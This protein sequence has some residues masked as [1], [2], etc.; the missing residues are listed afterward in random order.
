MASE[1]EKYRTPEVAKLAMSPMGISLAV[2]GVVAGLL[3]GSLVVGILLGFVLWASRIVVG[4]ARQG[5]PTGRSRS[6]EIDPFA[7]GEPWRH[8]VRDAMQARTRFAESVAHAGSGPLRDRLD[9]IG[10]R[11][12]D[13]IDQTW[14][15]A[16][17]GHELRRAR[18][19]IDTESVRHRLSEAESQL[20][21]MAVDDTAGRTVRA[22]QSQLDSAERLDKV[23]DNAERQLRLLQAQLDEATARASELAA[24]A[25]LG[26]TDLADVG[27]D[28]DHVVDE[29]EALR[30]ALDELGPG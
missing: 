2:V 12:D 7:L 30:L 16:Q 22:L 14:Q 28:I 13:G 4:I 11:L 19:R 29:M 23:I 6:R 20:D 10:R 25:S 15:T 27:A 18:N 1:I 24:G 17:K 3:A 26:D 8:F 21:D 5:P 9:S